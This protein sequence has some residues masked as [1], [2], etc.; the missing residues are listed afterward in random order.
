M[1]RGLALVLIALATGCASTPEYPEGKPGPG[2][3]TMHADKDLAWTWVTPGFDFAAYYTLLLTEPRTDVKDLKPDDA[4]SLE[5]ALG[6]LRETFVPVLRDSKLFKIVATR[7]PDIPPGAKVLRLDTTIM[8]YAK[9]NAG[10][11]AVGDLHAN[12]LITVL[13]RTLDGDR[14]VF[15]FEQRRSGVNT[16]RKFWQF[17]PNRDLQEADLSDIANRLVDHI[18]R[19]TGRQ[20]SNV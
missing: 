16:V 20:R 8:E 19:V 2:G 4:E 7:E 5:W 9:G 3:V 18:A 17:R 1:V 14:Q 11:R 10:A 13:G 6:V 12:P 15:V